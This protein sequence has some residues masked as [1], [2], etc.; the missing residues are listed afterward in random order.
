MNLDKLVKRTVPETIENARA[1]LKAV[2]EID[3]H[4]ISS[5]QKEHAKAIT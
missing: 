5:R 1:I 2:Q 3:Q 4:D